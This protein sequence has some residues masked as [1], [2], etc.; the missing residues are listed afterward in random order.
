MRIVAFDLLRIILTVLVVNVHIRILTGVTPNFLEPFAWYTVPLFIVVSFYFAKNTDLLLRIKRLLLPFFFWSVAGF[1]VH[2][3]LLNAKNILLQLVSGQVVNTP[4]YYL[5]L[6]I[7]FT[8][9]NRVIQKYAARYKF[10]IYTIVAATACYLEYSARN[11]TFFSSMTP[12]I[13][14]TYGRLIE[15]IPY[16]PVGLAFAAIR[17][18]F[19]RTGWIFLSLV[20]FI[21]FLIF[22]KIPQPPDFH[23]SGLKI[24]SG[25]LAVFSFTIWISEFKIPEPVS[26]VLSA[27]GRY[28][29][30]VYL[31]HYILLESVLKI[32]PSLRGFISSQQILFLMFLTASVYGFCTVFDRVTRKKVSFLVK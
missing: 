27:A 15:L 22:S 4:L 9:L 10:F 29:Y 12:V 13:A 14:K 31:T 3:Q 28:S 30:G 17:K 8:V 20:F 6:L 18:K 23:F 11:V 32:F 19:P 16:V 7:L 21:L 5:V 26:R 1:A 24:F 2:P 25:V